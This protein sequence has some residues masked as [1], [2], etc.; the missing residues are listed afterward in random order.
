MKIKTVK[1][2]KTSHVFGVSTERH[3]E[4]HESCEKAIRDNDTVSGALVQVAEQCNSNEELAFAMYWAGVIY[5]DVVKM[6]FAESLLDAIKGMNM[7]GEHAEK[8]LN[9]QDPRNN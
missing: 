4:I 8:I 3:K 6:Q 2:E 5:Q 1:A 9:G 7:A